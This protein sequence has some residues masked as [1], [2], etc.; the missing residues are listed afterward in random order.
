MARATWRR[1][2]T[3]RSCISPASSGVRWST[4]AATGSV[5]SRTRR[6]PGD[7][8]H[9]PSWDWS[10]PSANGTCSYP[11][12]G[13]RFEP[14]RVLFDGSP[15]GPAHF[16][17]RE[18]EAAAGPGPPGPTRHQLRRRPHHKANEI[19]L[20]KVADTWRSWPRPV[21]RPLLRRLLPGPWG[22]A[23]SRARGRLG[24]HRALRRPRSDVEAP[25]PVP[26]AKKLHPRRSP[27]WSRRRPMRR[28]RRS[29]DRLRTNSA[30]RCSGVESSNTSASSRGPRPAVLDDL[31]ALL[32][33]RRLDQ[34]GDLRR[35]QLLEL[36]VRDAEL[37]RRT[38]ANEGSMLAQ[39]TIGPGFGAFPGDP[40]AGAAA[41]GGPD[42]ST[43]TTPRCRPPW[44]LDLVRLMMR[45]PRS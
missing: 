3:G 17:R 8:P 9:R 31:L 10:S 44:Q 30:R 38:W 14:G 36:A 2:P 32:M 42:G 37:R 34:V 5:A 24:Q 11:S 25:H 27:T 45:P 4:S 16:E 22:R 6:A 29:S 18:G 40:E 20:A 13:G 15:G 1:T 26:Q 35:V 43:A 23:P 41:V 7:A 12:E 21:R 19:E 28:A 39:S 33:G